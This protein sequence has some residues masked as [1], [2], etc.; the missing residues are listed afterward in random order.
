[1]KISNALFF[2]SLSSRMKFNN[3]KMNYSPK[4]IENMA[5]FSIAAFSNLPLLFIKT[6]AAGKM[7]KKNIAVLYSN[8][9]YSSLVSKSAKLIFFKEV[10][11][12]HKI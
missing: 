12:G 11:L 9:S 3:L 6:Y 8:Y 4:L 7:Y 1:M 5:I 2:T 10:I